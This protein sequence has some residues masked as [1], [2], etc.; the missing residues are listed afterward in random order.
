MLVAFGLKL[1]GTELAHVER[2]C[3]RNC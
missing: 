3:L 2:D 1:V